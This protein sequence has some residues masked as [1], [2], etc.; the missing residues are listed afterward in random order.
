MML[1]NLPETPGEFVTR[2]KWNIREFSSTMTLVKNILRQY[3]EKKKK[4]EKD[5]CIEPY[6]KLDVYR[7]QRS[8]SRI[9]SLIIKL[10][11]AFNGD[12]LHRYD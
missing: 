2:I 9:Y 3:K 8:K 1:W 12:T 6:K 7:R 11:T 10:R 5:T 4:R